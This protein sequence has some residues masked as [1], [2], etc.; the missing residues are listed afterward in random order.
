[1]DQEKGIDY[2]NFTEEDIKSPEEV[3]DRNER[4]EAKNESEIAEEEKKLRI[5]ADAIGDAEYY[6]G[7]GIGAELA[8]GAIK[9]RHGDMDI[10]V[11]EEEIPKIKENLESKG[12]TV[13]E[14]KSFGGHDLD[15]RNFKIT[16][17]S[18]EPSGEDAVYIGI[19]VYKKNKERNTAQQLDSDG[20]INKEFPL[21]Y[22]DKDKQTLDYNDSKLTVADL[23]LIVGL[24]IISDRSKDMRDIERIKPLL[25]SKFGAQEIDE[26]KKVCNRNLATRD[27]ASVKYMFDSF[28]KANKE[29]NTENIHK[30]FSA[31][32]KKSIARMKDANYS[33]AA[34]KFMESI[35]SF[36]PKAKS[37]KKIREDFLAFASKKLEPV[38]KYQEKM[39][40]EV[41]G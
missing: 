15:A 9:H 1:M 25:K 10:I 5:F 31:E 16:E 19:F 26:M 13:T 24:K 12:F 3:F 6:I 33:N 27:L 21:E 36:S 14:G 37:R 17:E 2:R 22:F 7:G 29:I 41:L 18:D 8:E 39:V 23:R 32:L 30:H 34:R 20:D 38:V 40:G 28:L 11:F 35:K 4:R